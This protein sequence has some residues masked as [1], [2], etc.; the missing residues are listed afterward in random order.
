MQKKSF[1]TDKR[2]A[3]FKYLQNDKNFKLACNPIDF[4][5]LQSSH[6]I[7]AGNKRNCFYQERSTSFQPVDE[8]FAD[9]MIRGDFHETVCPYISCILYS[10]CD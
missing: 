8:I 10:F 5:F 9:N 3:T 4:N 7:P 6:F 1:E 2:S